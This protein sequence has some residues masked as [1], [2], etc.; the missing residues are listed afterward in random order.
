RHTPH[1]LRQVGMAM[2]VQLYN[3][4]CGWACL[5]F[6]GWI[7]LQNSS[8]PIPSPFAWPAY[9][10]LGVLLIAG[11]RSRLRTGCAVAAGAALALILWGALPLWTHQAYGV[12]ALICALRVVAGGWGAYAMVLTVLHWL[13]QSAPPMPPQPPAPEA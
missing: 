6:A 9:L 11:A 13:Q 7:W 4:L 2:Y 10:T 3:R 8:G 1:F 12:S 5:V